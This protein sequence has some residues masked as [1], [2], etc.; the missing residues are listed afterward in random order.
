MTETSPG[1][2]ASSDVVI[3]GAGIAG[4]AAAWYLNQA[5]IE[6]TVCEKGRIAGEQS[7]R[8]WG[9]IRQQGRDQDE[10]PIVMHSMRLWQEIADQL[11]ISRET[12]SLEFIKLYILLFIGDSIKTE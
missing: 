2:P 5:G 11:F 1:L 9:W 12:V 4:I 3:V 10:L 6:V 8:N 7:S